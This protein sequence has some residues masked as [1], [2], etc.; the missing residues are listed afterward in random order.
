MGVLLF[1]CG[2]AA[3]SK[4]APAEWDGL[5]K[6]DISGLDLVYVRPDSQFTAYK[7]VMIDPVQVAFAK[8]WKP[9]QRFDAQDLQ[10]IKDGLAGMVDEGFSKKLTA[11][12]YAV[13]T[14]PDDDTLRLSVAIA[15]LYIK[16]PDSMSPGRSRS[17][18]TSAGS[19][20]LVLEIR[21]STSGELL[22]RVIDRHSA[23]SG[24]TMRWTNSVTNRAEADRAIS[25][26][27]SQLVAELD[28]L[29]GKSS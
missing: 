7:K 20:V 8:N 14:T 3:V 21:D 22:A 25:A 9:P 5:E 28:R 18:T 11:G 23:S 10:K 26:W 6:R 29:N 15:D 17:Y 2:Y 19:M 27:A 13:T 16:A 24:G 1:A 4:D 12:G